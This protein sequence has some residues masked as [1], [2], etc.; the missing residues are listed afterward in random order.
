MKLETFTSVV[1]VS[2]LADKILLID[3]LIDIS[4][5]QVTNHDLP[6][7]DYRSERESGENLCDV[8]LLLERGY[9]DCDNAV[10]YFGAYYRNIGTWAVPILCKM[11]DRWHTVLYLTK[12]RVVVDPTFIIFPALSNKGV[13]ALRTPNA[14][15][16][17]EIEKQL[18]YFR[19]RGMKISG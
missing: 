6:Q 10:T 4:R 19:Q 7:L 8:A 1:D 14:L 17:S 16:R 2:N 18:D 11:I 13:P 15:E 5:P 9:G 3:R 12:Q